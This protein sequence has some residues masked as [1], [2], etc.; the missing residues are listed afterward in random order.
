MDEGKAN[1]DSK[2]REGFLDK[3]NTKHMESQKAAKDDDEEEERNFKSV[4]K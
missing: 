1:S 2:E 3:K 4:R